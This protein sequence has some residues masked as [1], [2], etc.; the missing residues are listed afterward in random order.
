MTRAALRPA[1]QREHA[2]VH[3]ASS[4]RGQLKNMTENLKSKYLPDSGIAKIFRSWPATIEELS[5]GQIE[6]NFT[7]FISDTEGLSDP[8][9]GPPFKYWKP[10]IAS[11][12]SRLKRDGLV[13]FHRRGGYWHLTPKGISEKYHALYSD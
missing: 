11:E 1:C 13:T 4:Q 2:G 8:F 3:L 9:S 6:R 7:K 5:M 12:V 10:S